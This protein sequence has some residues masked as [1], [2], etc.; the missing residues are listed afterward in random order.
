MRAAIWKH[1]EENL[2]I[3]ETE[4][5]VTKEVLKIFG[6]IYRSICQYIHCFNQIG[7]IMIMIK[8]YKIL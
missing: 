7:V 2:E 1:F 8:K 5:D 3:T 6:L 4:I